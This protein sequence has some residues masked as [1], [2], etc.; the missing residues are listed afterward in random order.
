MTTCGLDQPGGT[1]ISWADCWGR[2]RQKR[3]ETLDVPPLLCSQ[4]SYCTCD[5]VL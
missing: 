4:D 1:V 5:F 3:W 2:D